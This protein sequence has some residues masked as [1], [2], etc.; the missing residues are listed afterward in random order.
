MHARTADGVPSTLSRPRRSGLKSLLGRRSSP[1]KVNLFNSSHYDK[2]DGIVDSIDIEGGGEE[3]KYLRYIWRTPTVHETT[4]EN[5]L[6]RLSKWFF[7]GLEESALMVANQ[8]KTW[9]DKRGR[10]SSSAETLLLAM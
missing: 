10:T 9:V 3:A 1:A 5:S 4:E 2:S 6:R 7:D 8:V